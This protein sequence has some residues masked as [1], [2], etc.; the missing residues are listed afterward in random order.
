MNNNIEAKIIVITGLP[1]LA[2]GDRLANRLLELL[3]NRLLDDRPTRA[4][5]HRQGRGV[6]VRL[7][8]TNQTACE[9]R[10]LKATES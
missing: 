5:S 6:R 9:R 8:V 3:G 2:S 1:S 7:L 4:L 10:S